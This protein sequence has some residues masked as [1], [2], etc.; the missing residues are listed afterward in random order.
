MV[1]RWSANPLGMLRPELDAAFA[2]AGG[3][4][5]GGPPVAAR[6]PVVIVAVGLDR[7][8]R[9]VD[10]EGGRDRLARQAQVIRRDRE[11]YDLVGRSSGHRD[12][13]A[14]S[15]TWTAGRGPPAQQ[16][17]PTPA[18]CSASTA[19]AGASQPR[20]TSTA[21][22]RSSRASPRPGP[23]PWCGAGTPICSASCAHGTRCP[24]SWGVRHPPRPPRRHGRGRLLDGVASATRRP[25]VIV[26][27][28]SLR[29]RAR[30]RRAEHGHQ[31]VCPA[32]TPYL[33][34]SL[35][36]NES[37]SVFGAERAHSL[38]HQA[39]AFNAIQ[40]GAL[41][42][43]TQAGAETSARHG[44]RQRLLRVFEEMRVLVE[45]CL[46]PPTESAEE[47][48][49]G[50]QKPVNTFV[51]ERVINSDD[52]GSSAGLRKISP[53]GLVMPYSPC[54]NHLGAPHSNSGSIFG[55]RAAPPPIPAATPSSVASSSRTATISRATYPSA[56]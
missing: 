4:G 5:G 45:P 55:A 12:Q 16:R 44:L 18:P 37:A 10:Q 42:G 53:H 19:G 7:I 36:N 23:P 38:Q 25:M 27:A 26:A 8:C 50:R 54:K 46:R 39:I 13:D 30:N 47:T 49:E 14:S 41:E 29:W 32:L 15:C 20:K 35:P 33:S 52:P 24:R 56:F 9:Q 3:N 11:R 2:T 34:R 28:G 51:P 1:A 48:A 17:R 22:S 43:I 31:R 21:T 6:P 40:V